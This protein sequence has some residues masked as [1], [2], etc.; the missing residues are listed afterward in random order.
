MQ[1][2]FRRNQYLMKK[3]LDNWEL[4]EEE[5]FPVYLQYKAEGISRDAWQALDYIAETIHS[6]IGVALDLRGYLNVILE[7][8]SGLSVYNMHITDDGV[9][10]REGFFDWLSPVTM[11]TRNSEANLEA[12]LI[13][14][15]IEEVGSNVS[16][17]MRK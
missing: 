12:N 15:D 13:A 4:K 17:L 11:P 16:S 1:D 5:G 14:G 8:R 9:I 2:D 10:Y 7:G 3:S 6:P